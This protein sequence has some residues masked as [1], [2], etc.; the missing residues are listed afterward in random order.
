MNNP[1]SEHVARLLELSEDGECVAARIAANIVLRAAAG[2]LHA[3]ELLIGLMEDYDPALEPAREDG[4]RDG[5][6]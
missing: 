5:D 4:R 3:C 6:H 2:D 1:I